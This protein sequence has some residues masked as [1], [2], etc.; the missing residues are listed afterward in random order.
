MCA[1]LNEVKMPELPWCTIEE[2]IER[3]REIGVLG[4]FVI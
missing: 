3:L 2:G 4:G 1:T